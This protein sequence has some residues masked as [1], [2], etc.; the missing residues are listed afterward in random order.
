MT[1]SPTTEAYDLVTQVR[2]RAGLNALQSGLSKDQ[3][4]SKLM[5][6]RLFEFWCE[7]GIQRALNDG[8][9]FVK[10]EFVLY[11]ISRKSINETNGIIKQ[12]PGY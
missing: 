3:F 7:G 11:P 6:E 4:R 12:N 5:D 10:P 1:A 2:K 8:S 9:T